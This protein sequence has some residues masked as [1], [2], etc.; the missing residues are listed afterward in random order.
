MNMDNTQPP[1]IISGPSDRTILIILTRITI[2]AAQSFAPTA[3]DLVFMEEVV[4]VEP[5]EETSVEVPDLKALGWTW[6]QPTTPTVSQYCG[7]T[8]V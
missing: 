2:P 8:Y 1:S 5:V 4:E 7:S 6:A 3:P